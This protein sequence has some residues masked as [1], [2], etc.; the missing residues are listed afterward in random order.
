[1]AIIARSQE[2]MR[3]L[4][5]PD[6][7]DDE[8]EAFMRRGS[9]EIFMATLRFAAKLLLI[10]LVLYLLFLLTVTLF[11]DLK[12]ALLE[13][14]FSPVVIAMLTAGTL[15]YAWARKIFFARLSHQGRQSS[16]P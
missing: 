11:P 4:M 5:S 1:M 13:D 3:V 8:K 15:G 12:E 14:L 7:G 2:S 6:L 9:A 16:A 10:A